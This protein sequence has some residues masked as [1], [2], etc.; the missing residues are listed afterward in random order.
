M[1]MYLAKAS[2][3]PPAEASANLSLPAMPFELFDALDKARVMQGDELYFEVSDYY[4]FQY[5]APFIDD[6]TNLLELNALCQKLS[7]LDERQA[8]AFEGL[9]KMEVAKKDGP[10]SV[11]K[12]I[13]LAYSADCCHVVS[14]A[15]SDEALGKFYAENGFIPAV[16]GLPESTYKMLNFAYIGKEMREGEGGVFTS[17]GYVVQHTELANA[18]QDMHFTLRTPDYQILLEDMAGNRFELPRQKVPAHGNYTCVDCRIPMLMAAIDVAELDEI[19]AFAEI[20]EN[21]GDSAVRQF[22]AALYATDCNSLRNAVALAEHLEE[23]MLDSKASSYAEVASTEVRFL[24]GDNDVGLLTQYLN[25]NGY[26]QALMKRD[27]A[28]L[29]PYGHLVRSDYQPLTQ[30]IEHSGHS[31]DAEEAPQLSTDLRMG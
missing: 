15:T 11:G 17:H 6:S 19:N 23:Y 2:Y 7:E 3:T 20:L 30:S 24:L 21:M 26:G 13:N 31:V 4:A 16:E 10:I 9:L 8:A 1:D 14:Q 5:M 12:L 22:K 25:L 28:V 27:N 18:Y 29:T